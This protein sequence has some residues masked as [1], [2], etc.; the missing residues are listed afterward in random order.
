MAGRL[1][2]VCDHVRSDFN[3]Y[4]LPDGV[5]AGLAHFGPEGIEY[6]LHPRD[7]KTGVAYRLLPMTRGIIAG[8]FSAEQAQR[9]FSLMERH[10]AFPDGMRL[11]NRPMD[12]HG[13]TSRYFKRAESAA[14]FGREVGLQYVQAHIRHVEAMAR[15]GRPD[16]AFR[17]LLAVCPIALERRRAHCPPPPGQRLLQQL[18]CGVPGPPPG[19]PRVRPSPDR[20]RGG[21]GRLAGLLERARHL[22]QRA[23]LER[24]RPAQLVRRRGAGPRAA[25]ACRRPDVRLED[26]GRRVRYL[27]HVARNGF[28]PRKVHVNGRRLPD[29]RHAENPYRAGGMLV[30]K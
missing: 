19:Q 4:L 22:H 3:R 8:L 21:Q 9:H 17:G 24:A 29:D 7:R 6:F 16:E 23:D 10:L 20:P 5:V 26:Q 13:G 30:P 18:R 25:Q 15:I 12:Y 28:S 2:K 27:Y 14:N 1:A 11:M